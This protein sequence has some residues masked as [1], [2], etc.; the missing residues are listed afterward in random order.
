MRLFSLISKM[1]KTPRTI[2]LTTE[3]AERSGMSVNRF[4]AEKKAIL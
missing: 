3:F 4:G 1:R 2:F